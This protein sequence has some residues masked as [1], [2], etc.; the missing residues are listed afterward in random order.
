MHNYI[1]GTGVAYYAVGRTLGIA[2]GVTF[3]VMEDPVTM[4][5]NKTGHL[6]INLIRLLGMIKEIES[7]ERQGKCVINI[8]M[9]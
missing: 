8:S 5:T 6:E 3:L 7:K 4:D 9:V 2:P 1:H